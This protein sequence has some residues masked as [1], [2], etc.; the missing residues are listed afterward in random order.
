V[1]AISHGWAGQ[2][3]EHMVAENAKLCAKSHQKE[4][5][6]NHPDVEEDN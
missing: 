4:D 2:G 3:G 6:E 5:V 1:I